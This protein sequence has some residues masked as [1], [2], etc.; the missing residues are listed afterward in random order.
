M[1]RLGEH[2]RSQPRRIGGTI[3]QNGNLTGARDHIDAHLTGHQPF[4][5]GH[6][7][8]ARP[9]DDIHPGD[10]LR[11]IGQGGDSPGRSAQIDMFD[12]QN[13]GSSQNINFLPNQ[14]Q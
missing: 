1:L 7:N 3:G 11:S 14:F 8:I 9:G 6:K 10:S 4:G 5:R 13:G 12:A 2:V